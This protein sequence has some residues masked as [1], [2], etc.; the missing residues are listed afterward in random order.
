VKTILTIMCVIIILFAG[1]C[2]ITLGSI[3]ANLMGGFGLPLLAMVALNIA[4]LAAL[5][6]WANVPAWPLYLLAGIDFILAAVFGVT[7]LTSA[8][9]LGV[10]TFYGVVPV[11]I[12]ALKGYLTVQVAK[13]L[14]PSV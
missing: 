13:S 6:G 14:K 8:N 12:A 1:G 7:T 4:V 9:D 11:A 3:D 2:A 5:Y 10:S